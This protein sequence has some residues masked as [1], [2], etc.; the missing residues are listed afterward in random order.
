MP[1]GVRELLDTHQRF[2]R[3]GE[4]LASGDDA[5]L[6]GPSSMLW[7][8]NR[9]A[10]LLAGGGRALIL[11][12]AH[13]LV[14]AGVAQHSSYKTDPLGRLHRSL[15]I[16]LR[17]I[18]GDTAAAERASRAFRAVHVRVVGETDE[19]AGRYPAG[20]P[21]DSRADE[22]K[23]WV[24]ATLTDTALVAYQRF[25]GALTRPEL[26]RYYEES[27]VLGDQYGIP[28]SVQPPSYA[29]FR[30]YFEA[31][32]ASDRIALTSTLRELVE[33]LREPPLP[34]IGVPLARAAGLF[35][36]AT[37]PV[38]LREELG[39][40]WGRGREAALAAESAAI[41]RLLP[42]MPHSLRDFPAALGAERR[43]RRLGG[44]MGAGVPAAI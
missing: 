40:S 39:L 25:V 43:L 41:R 33:L 11:Q 10:V 13:P 28:R 20:T 29:D 23:M 22:L 18:F 2:R 27:L 24:H 38:R 42:L 3:T 7:R 44:A 30:A 14:A 8:V 37:L 16:P 5:G 32:V 36:T 17:I 35:T 19:S 26:E 9:E 1:P 34:V 12:V 21:Y 15:D 31:T 6:F 4:D